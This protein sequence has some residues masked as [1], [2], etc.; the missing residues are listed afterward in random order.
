MRVLITWAIMSLTVLQ[1]NVAEAKEPKVDNQLLC[2]AKN[3]YYE[4]GLETREIGRAH[5]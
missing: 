5:V 2:L 3:I 4:A 1:M